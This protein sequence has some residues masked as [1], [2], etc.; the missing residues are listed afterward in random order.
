MKNKIN[1][2]SNDTIIK[3]AA[4]ETIENPASIIK[5][6]VENSIDANSN[7]ITIEVKENGSRYI[8]VSDNGQGIS[9]EDLLI[10]FKRHATSKIKNIDE[11]ESAI[12]LGFRGEALSSIANV[13]D[14][15]IITKTPESKLGILAYIDKNGNITSMED[16]VCNNGTT[17]ICENLFE[18]IP[19]RKKYLEEKNYEISKTNE[20]INKLSLANPNI[21]IEYIRDDRLIS[22][23]SSNYSFI[24][25]IFSI[26]GKNVSENL[27]DVE[28]EVLGF[29]IRGFIGNNRLYKANRQGQFIFVNNRTINDIN[30]SRAVER[31]YKSII[32]INRYPIFILFL[33]IN[34]KLIDINIHPK[35][36]Q[37]KFLNFEFIEN[38]LAKTIRTA[39]NPKL[40]IHEISNKIKKEESIF[41]I[42]TE[43]EYET[44]KDEP[45]VQNKVQPIKFKDFSN[46]TVE[47]NIIN[48]ENINYLLENEKGFFIE[49]SPKQVNIYDN[50]MYKDE[51]VSVFNLFPNGYRFVGQLFFQ[52]ILLEDNK[53]QSL[54]ILDQHAAHERI[55][56][57]K[58][59]KAYD[60]SSI[61]RQQ[62]V[63]GFIV[64]LTTNE[65]E[66][67]MSLKDTIESV[68]FEIE[69]FGDNSIIIRSIPV[70][71]TN[72]DPEKLLRDILDSPLNLKSNYYDLDPYLLMKKACVASIKSGDRLSS[73]D[74]K[75]L[76]DQLQLCEMPLTCPHGRP[77]LIKFTKNKLDKEFFRIQNEG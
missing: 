36:D 77:T 71:L 21:S 72:I 55:N 58:L 51:D 3:I 5:E 4:G 39:L 63:S 52:Y 61:P 13:S 67:I 48:D 45:M 54:Y 43:K 30:I 73:H 31:E 29:K 7:D 18:N 24:N 37:I 22:K 41:D 69:D 47:D 25:N 20:I 76:I 50:N 9:K 46:Y 6:L 11:L 40:Q 42:F 19:V 70:Y 33:E 14:V 65:H 15:K 1:I 32:P 28:G 75:I 59:V 49:D 64:N 8:R 66:K 57:E 2:L 56:Y 34:P 16:I 38:I 12:T 10:A 23:T 60:D 62:L 53:D 35:K 44:Q 68:G 17:I 74:V 27:I 26:L